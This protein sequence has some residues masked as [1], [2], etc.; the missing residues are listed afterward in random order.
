MSEV[1]VLCVVKSD[2]QADRGSRLRLVAGP[3]GEWPAEL[4]GWVQVGLPPA[5]GGEVVAWEPCKA[6]ARG[7]GN[8]LKAS[9]D[10]LTAALLASGGGGPQAAAARPDAAARTLCARTP[11]SV[12]TTATAA[13]GDGGGRSLCISTPA[14]AH[15][16]SDDGKPPP[17]DPR[18]G[19]SLRLHPVPPRDLAELGGVGIV[20]TPPAAS[21]EL[22]SSISRVSLLQKLL[23]RGFNLPRGRLALKIGPGRPIVLA[24]ELQDASDP[25]AHGKRVG[26]VTRTTLLTIR[27]PALGGGE[28]AGTSPTGGSSAVGDHDDGYAQCARHLRVHA[29]GLPGEALATCAYFVSE[30]MEPGSRVGDTPPGARPAAGPGSGEE[31]L[32]QQCAAQ[33]SRRPGERV[34]PA[35]SQ[36]LVP[37]GCTDGAAAREG[38]GTAPA[39]PSPAERRAPLAEPAADA[40]AA[41]GPS[42][43]GRPDAAAGDAGAAVRA[44]FRA[45]ASR[46]LVIDGPSGSGKTHLAAALAEFCRARYGAAVVRASAPD[47]FR[48]HARVGGKAAAALAV[49]D[50][51]DE[52]RRAGVGVF[53]LDGIDTLN[54]KDTVDR[55]VVLQLAHELEVSC[56]GRW[57]CVG[58]SRDWKAVDPL[59]LGVTRFG[60]IV[61]LGALR[62]S[63]RRDVLAA[64]VAQKKAG[65]AS[66]NS[67]SS[68]PPPQS[69]AELD[70]D[71]LARATPG[72]LPA[73]LKAVVDRRQGTDHLQL[74]VPS[75]PDA[76]TSPP[77]VTVPRI[78]ATTPDWVLRHFDRLVGVAGIV[79]LFNVAVISPLVHG[80]RKPVKGLLLEGP[81]GSGKTEVARCMAQSLCSV[82]GARHG[83]T[84]FSKVEVPAT[85]VVSKVVGESEENVRKLFQRA[86]DS[87]PSVL[88]IDQFEAIARARGG[89]GATKAVD[90]ML[91]TLLT[92][93]D[94]VEHDPTAPPVLVI[95]CTSFASTLDPA[96]L[97]SGRLDL[98]VG[99]PSFEPRCAVQLFEMRIVP[100][101][102]PETVEAGRSLLAR[103]AALV[104][105]YAQAAAFV[106][107]AKMA[108][109]RR[110]VLGGLPAPPLL[111]P[112][113]LEDALPSLRTAACPAS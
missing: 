77:A 96:V 62:V 48:T 87:A 34:N 72:F 57:L 66:D 97:R 26:I 59:L 42:G 98:H 65:S 25:L 38:C 20:V 95:A 10:A 106:E 23:S 71:A 83:F 7:D 74:L 6:T 28:A 35:N 85:A 63:H 69:R 108:C 93:M 53:V 36:A 70:V 80:R 12:G 9:L 110:T 58:T 4:G 8:G 94:G 76:A 79:S 31:A 40:S 11:G 43:G 61:R 105:G 88:V 84:V 19:F 30:A 99:M 50:C 17:S 112:S 16:S 24:L 89:P 56:G 18:A 73:Q 27:H 81:P 39:G 101:L 3:R 33:G 90:R 2:G 75:E 37:R 104:A 54:T 111:V 102:S 46:G 21:F 68:S 55:L 107:A 103:A 5:A 64:I 100:H 13:Q 86:R 60:Y 32:V 113:D 52:I 92:E 1:D 44:G 49:Q 45:L 14:S 22:I 78:P 51:F 41:P 91:S 82:D 15:S 47:L 109:V 29:A 67:S